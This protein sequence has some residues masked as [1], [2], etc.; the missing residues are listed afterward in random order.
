MNADPDP[1]KA[2]FLEA[3]ERHAA[4]QSPAFLDGAC[5][6]RPELRGRPETLLAAP[7]EVG[8]ARLRDRADGPD[9]GPAATVARPLP[10]ERPGA[11]IGPYKLVELSGEG[12]MGSVWMAQQPEPVRRLVA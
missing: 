6:G 5:A 8:T 4:G 7:R 9:P 12:G 10:A 11:V 2:V 3:V 1:A